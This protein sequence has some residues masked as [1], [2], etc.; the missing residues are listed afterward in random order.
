MAWSWSHSPSAYRDA[1][2]SLQAIAFL[3]SKG[4]KQSQE[5]L[6]TVAAEWFASNTHKHGEHW[7]DLKRYGK[8][9]R[10][11]YR[12]ATRRQHVHST[13]D[14]GWSELAEIIWSKAEEL[15]TCDNGGWNC[16]ICPYGCHTVPFTP[17]KFLQ[18]VISHF[19]VE[20]YHCDVNED[21]DN[22]YEYDDPDDIDIKA[23]TI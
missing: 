5:K 12:I 13:F 20:D 16:W 15:Q 18:Y 4:S 22:G 21:D 10:K 1:Q 9:Q 7:L 17:S 11:A 14:S 6:L 19:I 23:I 3:A 2:L 8:A